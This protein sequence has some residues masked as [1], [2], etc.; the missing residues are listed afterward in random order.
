MTTP[1]LDNPT[2]SYC[3][4]LTYDDYTFAYKEIYLLNESTKKYVKLT[5]KQKFDLLELYFDKTDLTTD[6]FNSTTV[7]VK[8]FVFFVNKTPYKI[9]RMFPTNET[10]VERFNKRLPS[11]HSPYNEINDNVLMCTAVAG[12]KKTTS[13]PSPAEFN[14]FTK[15][16]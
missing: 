3:S 11:I 13:Y 2:K 9:S 8:P 4:T 12:K 1:L 10:F 15:T 5:S 7:K 6:E 14:K 16:L